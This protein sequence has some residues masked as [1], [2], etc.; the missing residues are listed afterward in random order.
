MRSKTDGYSAY[1][2]S[3]KIEKQAVASL[4]LVST[5]AATDGVTY[6]FFQKMT[7]FLSHRLRTVMIFLAVVYL[8]PLY[9]DTL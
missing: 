1:R 5:G 6:F 4:R 7:T 2:L 9:G 8:S 3:L